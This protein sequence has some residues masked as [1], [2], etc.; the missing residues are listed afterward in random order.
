MTRIIVLLTLSTFLLTPET[1]WTQQLMEDPDSAFSMAA[2]AGKNVLL[3]FSGS[4]WCIPCIRFEKKILADSAFQRFAGEKLVI[5]LAD[6]PQRKKIRPSLRAQYEALAEQFN[7][8][9]NFPQIVL[10]NPDK[11]LVATF[12]YTDQSPPDFI[13]EIRHPL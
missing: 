8:L 3:V 13:S 9:G 6:F 12:S 5:L 1:A 11:K 10:L 2:Q 7:P 4:D